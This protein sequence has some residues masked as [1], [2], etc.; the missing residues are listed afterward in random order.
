MGSDAQDDGAVPEVPEFRWEHGARR[1]GNSC[2]RRKD[3]SR[4][5][6]DD[7]SWNGTRTQLGAE[8]QTLQHVH[9][10]NVNTKQ[11]I[12]HM[13]EAN[14]LHIYHNVERMNVF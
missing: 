11:Q 3:D 2:P 5:E 1:R 13:I 4:A 9:I 14:R 6:G 8:S 10:C 12:N 7:T